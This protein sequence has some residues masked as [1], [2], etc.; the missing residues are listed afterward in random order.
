VFVVTGRPARVRSQKMFE[1]C[2]STACL[3]TASGYAVVTRRPER[4]K[5]TSVGILD[6]AVGPGAR[7]QVVLERVRPTIALGEQVVAD[8]ERRSQHAW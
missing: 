6:A 7:P 3:V 5:G 2:C 1:A 4:R 8:T